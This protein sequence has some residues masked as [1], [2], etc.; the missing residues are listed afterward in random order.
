MSHPTDERTPRSETVAPVVPHPST[1]PSVPAPPPLPHP[2]KRAIDALMRLTTAS[3]IPGQPTLTTLGSPTPPDL[4]STSVRPPP[5]VRAIDTLRRLDQRTSSVPVPPPSTVL[6]SPG[7]QGLDF[8]SVTPSPLPT[9]H[10]TQL[11]NPLPVPT[12]Q[13]AVDVLKRMSST[14]KPPAPEP[15]TSMPE[16]SPPANPSTA[17][18]KKRRLDEVIMLSDSD[19]EQSDVIE[20]SDSDEEEAVRLPKRRAIIAPDTNHVLQSRRTA[21]NWLSDEDFEAWVISREAFHS[22]QVDRD[23]TLPASLQDLSYSYV[24][25]VY[26]LF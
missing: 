6:F 3:S 18:Y 11:Q 14:P 8:K 10:T 15:I 2:R 26:F 5:R 24:S 13:R 17:P 25:P 22:E 16:P 12:N 1:P 4:N 7:P 21:R 20:I 19:A 23:R 9:I